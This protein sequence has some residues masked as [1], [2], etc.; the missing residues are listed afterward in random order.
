VTV[1][2]LLVARKDDDRTAL[3]TAED[4]RAWSWRQ[5]VEESAVRASALS[6]L[7]QTRPLHIGVLLEN[8]PEYVFVL[9]GVALAGHVVVGINPTRRGEELARDIRTTDCAVVLTDSTQARLLDS[10]DLGPSCPVLDVDGTRWKE[11]LD[12]G[13]G[14]RL[15]ATLPGSECLYLLLFTSGS[16]GAPKAVRVSQGRAARTAK[17]SAAAFTPDDVLY[18]AMPLFHGNALFANLFPALAA[19]ASLVLRPRFSASEFVTDIRRFGCTYFNYVGRALSYILAVPESPEEKDNQLKWGLGSEASPRDMAEFR[20]RYGTPVIEGY[21]SSENAVVIQPV[22]GTPPGAIGRPRE[23]LEVAVIDPASGE[24]CPPARFGEHGA[25]LNAGEAIGEIVGL[26]AL[27]LFEGYYANPEA[28]AERTRHGW[29]WTGD[30]GYRDA[31][32]FF[33]FAGRSADWLRV[34]GENFGAAPVER[35]LSRFAG[36]A[37]VAVYAVPDPDTADQVM[38]AIE[39]DEG[40]PLDVEAFASFLV[41]QEDLGTKWAPR[42]IRI[43]ERLPVTATR[44]VDKQPLRQ[45]RWDTADPVWWRPAR[46]ERYRLMSELDVRELHE[47]FRRAGRSA[48]LG[49]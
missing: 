16:T 18:C 4:G 38:A 14:S 27:P 12:D 6:A 45:E 42:F 48:V 34:D 22:P 43:V 15:P 25:L 13:R 7:S 2:A 36:V 40:V 20:R 29:Y 1:A 31:D 3:R 41:E 47:A 10:L 17:V 19:G 39:M 49:T 5:V 30:L 33:Y 44:K 9:G 46:E 32:G 23:G 21:G 11:L 37:A 8:V 24:E 28:E 26:N 35:I